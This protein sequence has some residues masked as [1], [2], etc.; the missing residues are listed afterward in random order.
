MVGGIKCGCYE[1]RWLYSSMADVSLPFY[2]I[3]GE[4]FSE[5]RKKTRSFHVSITIEKKNINIFIKINKEK[6][7]V[8]I[9]LYTHIHK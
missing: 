8:I 9:K 7:V 3:I 6:F 1:Q 5:D 4:N 2:S